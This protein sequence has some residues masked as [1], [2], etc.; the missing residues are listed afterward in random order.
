MTAVR[1]LT[2]G[3]L[4]LLTFTGCSS[5]KLSEWVPETEYNPLV[6]SRETFKD[7]PY[8]SE[9]IAIQRFMN[10]M[11][12][13]EL[14]AVRLTTSKQFNS[15][16]LRHP[17]SYK[18]LEFLN[19]PTGE[20]EVV[21]ID[22]VSGT[23]KRVQAAIG[24]N[25][26]NLTFLLTFNDEI[27]EWLVDN[28]FMKQKKDGVIAV[29]S[30]SDQMQLLVTVREFME[31]AQSGETD[32]LLALTSNEFKE[33]LSHIPEKSFEKMREKIAG[34]K[35][36]KTLQPQAQFD[37]N[38]AMVKIHRLSGQ[39]LMT[40]VS[41]EGSWKVDD[42][43]IESR[44]DQYHVPSLRR[45]AAVM[46]TGI[47]FLKAYQSHDHAKLAEVSDS[48]F[49]KYVLKNADLS[50]FPLPFE[51]ILDQEYRIKASGSIAMIVIPAGEDVVTLDLEVDDAS[52]TGTKAIK[53]RVREVTHFDAA[54]QQQRLLS[55]VFTSQA[56]LKAFVSALE[57]RDLEILQRLST[58][59]FNKQVWDRLDRE[60]VRTLPIE[61]VGHGTPR[62]I[63]SNYQ[64]DLTEFRLMQGEYAITYQIR[65]WNGEQLV[66]DILVTMPNRPQSLKNTLALVVPVHQFR[67][68]IVKNDLIRIQKSVSGDFNRLVWKHA[69][70]VPAIAKST[71][72]FY[73]HP[74]EQV[75]IRANEADLTLGSNNAGTTV[76]LIQEHEQWL[77]DEI[78]LKSPGP[79][80]KTAELKQAMR[81]QV[82]GGSPYVTGDSQ[83]PQYG[84]TY[85][86]G[87]QQVGYEQ[88][89][90]APIQPPL[91]Q[92][93]TELPL[94]QMPSLE[95][96]SSSLDDAPAND[97]S[98][99]TQ[100]TSSPQAIPAYGKLPH[101]SHKKRVNPMAPIWK[102]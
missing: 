39:I 91:N 16:A 80:M 96:P 32:T 70:S 11:E 68:G 85:S 10:A 1:R 65:D 88:P 82:S 69:P 87:V 9:K 29:R 92:P 81:I 25:K 71:V 34:D 84:T 20:V 90:S 54:N 95:I 98:G 26:Q 40:L 72:G 101:E 42:I 58:P 49:Y 97:A 4:T 21:E 44:E 27:D 38:Q 46:G 45:T 51:N 57:K 77:I 78:L 5:F 33:I 94:D 19:I 75:R 53:Y 62:M 86:G 89:A 50:S 55:S 36:M 12:L 3:L 74:I 67:A 100:P 52:E 41:N 28:L 56:T 22:H 24:E 79:Q 30:V 59:D 37:E 61:G 64:G 83:P 66:D 102:Q 43:A 99:V 60:T 47:E 18:D 76:R 73:Q 14:D 31:S 13:E 48:K 7:D 93:P 8:E 23:E 15:T 2:L 6:Y 63:W 17:D 35:P